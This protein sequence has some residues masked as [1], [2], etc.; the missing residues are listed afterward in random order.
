M[1][2]NHQANLEKQKIKFPK[3]VDFVTA[4]FEEVSPSTSINQ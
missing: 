2:K 3:I 1:L 4:D